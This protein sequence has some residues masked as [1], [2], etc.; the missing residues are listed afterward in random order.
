MNDL[1]EKP[2]LLKSYLLGELNE[3][4]REEVE[5]RLV[6][7][8]DFFK[9]SLLVE[10][11]L[12]DDYAQGEL[13]ADE[14]K[15]FEATILLT[16]RGRQQVELIRT[17]RKYAAE[18]SDEEEYPHPVAP[19]QSKWWQQL[20]ASPTLRLATAVVVVL[21]VGV[22]IWQGLRQS[23]VDK[24]L[25]ALKKAYGSQRPFEARIAE[26][27]YAPYVIPRGNQPK[28]IDTLSRDI[29]ERYLMDAVNNQPTAKSQYA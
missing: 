29:A 21:A 7:D 1:D 27:D 18:K 8:E 9:E 24:G 25:A 16:A 15:K 19:P 4:Q 17:L 26:F 5:E 12:I 28:N 2:K 13:S 20:F 14:R 23:D 22:G 10:D 11:D 6:M 3:Q